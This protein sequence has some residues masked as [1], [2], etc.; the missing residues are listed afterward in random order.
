M[1]KKVRELFLGSDLKRKGVI[2]EDEIG[3]GTYSR[4]YNGQWSPKKKEPLS[5]AIKV[6]DESKSREDFLEI[7]LPREIKISKQIEHKNLLTTLEYFSLDKMTYII[8]DLARYDLLQYLRMKGALRE[9]LS[10]RLFFEL[11][12]G[13]QCMHEN[14]LV[15]RDIKCENLLIT[16]DGTLKIGDFGFAR[17]FTKDDTSYTYCGSTAYTAPEVISS[18]VGYNAYLSDTWSCGIILF[19]MLTGAMPFNKNNLNAIIKAKA[20]Q[21]IYPSNFG[22]T[23]SSDA[24]NLIESILLFDPKKRLRLTEIVTQLHPWY[25]KGF[26]KDYQAKQ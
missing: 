11:S 8:T 15:H 12:S 25:H 20:V 14:D 4:V 22:N 2:L 17:Q 23:L 9:T 6:I 7:F 5:V 24:R 18:K 19:V 10:R 3:S 21:V 16:S 26:S 1:L 13:I